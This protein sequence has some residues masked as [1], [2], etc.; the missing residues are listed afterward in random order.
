MDRTSFYEWKRRGQ[1]HGF[2]GLKVP[3][4]QKKE[5]GSGQTRGP[6]C[7]CVPNGQTTSA[8]L[9]CKHALPCGGSYDFVRDRTADGRVYRALNIIDEY[10]SEARM[11]RVALFGKLNSGDVL[12]ALTDFFLLRGPPRML[13]G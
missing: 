5:G 10:A 9:A 7:A 4:K 1:T 11:I 8:S 6:A 2:E 3:E 12:D 13:A